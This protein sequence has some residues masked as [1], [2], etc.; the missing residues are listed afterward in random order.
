M[1]QSYLGGRRKQSWET[2]R[3]RDLGGRGEKEG[4]MGTG[5]GMGRGRQERSPE[6]QQNEWKYA[7]SGGGRWVDTLECTRDLG[8]KRSSGLRGRDFR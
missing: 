4:G 3:R 5:S 7:T 1:L 8:G 2:E 6:G